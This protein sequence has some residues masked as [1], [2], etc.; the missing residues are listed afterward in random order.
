MT[1]RKLT[2]AAVIMRARTGDVA[3]H[4][5]LDRRER[6]DDLAARKFIAEYNGYTDTDAVREMRELFDAE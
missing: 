2:T 6:A 1:I 3:A 5:E 4:R